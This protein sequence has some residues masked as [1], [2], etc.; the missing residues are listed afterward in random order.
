MPHI[1]VGVLADLQVC[2]LHLDNS[3]PA[4]KDRLSCNALVSPVLPGMPAIP[5]L[6]LLLLSS[7]LPMQHCLPIPQQLAGKTGAELLADRRQE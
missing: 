6:S 3:Q 2:M 1:R 4:L 5:V 7:L